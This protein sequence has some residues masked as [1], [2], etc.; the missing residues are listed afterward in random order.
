M[1]TR[2]PSVRPFPLLVALLVALTPLAMAADAKLVVDPGVYD[3]RSPT[4]AP[5]TAN[6]RLT[7]DG[8]AFEVHVVRSGGNLPTINLGFS[9]ETP[10]IS[11]RD[12]VDLAEAIRRSPRLRSMAGGVVIE[13]RRTS[14]AQVRDAYVAAL[15]ALG[16]ELESTVNTRTWQFSNGSASVRLS[17]SPFGQNVTAYV[18]R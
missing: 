18:G 8:S 7:Y 4:R 15:G 10:R 16:F 14:E 12:Q 2:Q 1:S 6:V 3:V 13:H 17:L 11:P 5:T 9:G